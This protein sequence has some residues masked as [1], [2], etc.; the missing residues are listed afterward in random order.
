MV[1]IK[2]SHN[3]L[4]L[5]YHH[6]GYAIYMNYAVVL[7][8]LLLFLL[9]SNYVAAATSTSGKF[10]V[11]ARV[12]AYHT[13]IVDDN[14]MIIEII[15]NSKDFA[16]VRAYRNYIHNETSIELSVTQLAQYKRL[17]PDGKTN[18]LGVAY[19]FYDF[20]ALSDRITKP[21]L[22]TEILGIL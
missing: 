12:P 22:P 19:K 8:M 1:T 5:N 21:Q 13:V 3:R 9:P 7:G 6:A 15:S 4:L 10:T 20:P 14:G 11:S 17:F 18:E 16:E 2:R